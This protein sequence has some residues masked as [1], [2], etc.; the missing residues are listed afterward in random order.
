[1]REKVPRSTNTHHGQGGHAGKRTTSRAF[2]AK[3]TKHGNKDLASVS[4]YLSAG[5]GWETENQESAVANR[6]TTVKQS[7]KGGSL[8]E[9]TTEIL[10][11]HSDSADDVND[12]QHEGDI[13][14]NLAG[15]CSYKEVLG[16]KPSTSARYM[17]VLSGTTSPT[18]HVGT[19]GATDLKLLAKTQLF[20]SP[21]AQPAKWS[22]GIPTSR[23]YYHRYCPGQY[24][25]TSL[26]QHH[27]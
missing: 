23:P 16:C 1:M 19:N 6:A 14:T 5:G 25:N 9:S 4:A 2:V 17:T 7:S 27:G 22:K 11:E 10:K 21:Y 12:D 15:R 8:G 24:P 18:T 13:H 3:S 20:T 26:L